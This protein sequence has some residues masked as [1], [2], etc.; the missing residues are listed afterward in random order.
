LVPVKE[1]TLIGSF[2]GD[3]GPIVDDVCSSKA[4]LDEEFIID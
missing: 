2:E 3:D 4:R 1:G